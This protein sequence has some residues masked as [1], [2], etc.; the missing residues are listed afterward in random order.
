MRSTHKTATRE[1]FT[2]QQRLST[3]KNKQANKIIKKKILV[4][5]LLDV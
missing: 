3:A 1:K 5:I 4:G 2:Q